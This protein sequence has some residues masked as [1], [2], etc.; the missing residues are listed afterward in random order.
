MYNNKSI[1]TNLDLEKIASSIGLKLDGIYSIDELKKIPFKPGNYILNIG[2]RHW[3]AL[4]NNI[5]FDTFG[6]IYPPEV[7]NWVS[8]HYK[9]I[10]YNT[11]QIQAINSGHCGQYSILWLRYGDNMLD[12]FEQLNYF[13]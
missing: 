5:Y 13:Q 6:M 3:V 7:S 2:N 12:K 11:K 9:K 8:S 1:T 4:H 10:I